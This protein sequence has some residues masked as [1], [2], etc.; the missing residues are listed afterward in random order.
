MQG[1]ISFVAASKPMQLNRLV[2]ALISRKQD[3]Q[4]GIQDKSP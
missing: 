3:F 1:W 4:T 2:S